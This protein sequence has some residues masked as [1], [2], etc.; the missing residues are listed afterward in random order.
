MKPL[1]TLLFILCFCCTCTFEANAQEWI[2]VTSHYLQN[3][4]FD[5]NQ[6]D[7]WQSTISGGKREARQAA[8]HFQNCSFNFWQTVTDLPDGHYRLSARGFYRTQEQVAAYA[9][10]QQGTEEL[11]AYLYADTSR[12]LL[13]SIFSDTLTASYK[14]YT[15]SPNEADWFPSA[16]HGAS[17]AF[18]KGLYPGVLVEF[19]VKGGRLTVGV[20]CEGYLYNNWCVMDD[21]K[22]EYY[23]TKT[24]ATSLTFPIDTLHLIVGEKRRIEPQMLPLDATYR[25]VSWSS[26][27]QRVATIDS[28]GTIYAMAEGIT[29]VRAKST[30]GS[31]LTARCVVKVE[32][33]EATA[34]SLV[35]NELQVANIDMFLDPSF[36]YGSWVELHNPTDRS[37]SIKGFYVSDDPSD[38][39]RY[40]L[41]GDKEII[42]AHG[43]HVIWFDHYGD[44]AP[45]QIDTKLDCDG[46]AIYISNP[47]G[48]LVCSMTY[49]EALSR[50][51]YARTTD[52]AIEWGITS[53]PTP[54]WSNNTSVFSSVRLD[55]PM[56]DRD[57][58]LFTTPFTAKVEIPEGCTLRYTTDGTSPTL[59]RGEVSTDGLFTVDSTVVYRFRLFRD[60][61][62]PSR[63]VTRSYIYKDKEFAL[64]VLSVATDADHLYDDSIGIFV[65]GVNG[66]T[67][68]GQKTPCNYNMEW[69]RPVSMELILPDGRMVVN[70]EANMEICGGYSRNKA[71][72][73]FKLK[74]NKVYDGENYIPY[75]IFPRKA[76]MKH[77]TWQIRN[78]G[79]DFDCRIK[80]AAVHEIVQ[81]SG[82]DVDGLL[83]QPVVCFVNG[84]YL[85]MMNVRETS[86]KHFIEA[87]YGLDE[88]EIDQFEMT[89]DR[90]AQ[91]YGTDEAFLHWYD[92]ASRS[93]DDSV[94]DELCALVDIDAYVNFMAVQLYMCGADWPQNNVKGFRPLREGGR[95]RLILYDL[96][97]MFNTKNPFTLL[98][99][100]KFVEDSEGN[101]NEVQLVTIFHNLLQNDR[102][103]RRFIDTFALV[104]GSVFDNSRVRAIADSMA[105]AT[106]QALS[107]EGR[108]PWSSAG[109]LKSRL[110][111]SHHRAMMDTLRTYPP[112]QMEGK[113][114]Q[115]VSFSSNLPQARLYMNRIPVPTNRFSGV[116]FPSVT[117]K[118]EAP[119]GYRFV[120]WVPKENPTQVVCPTE[121][122]SLPTSGSHNLVARYE[123]VGNEELPASGFCPVRINEVSAANDIYVSP[124]YFK[125]SDW[126]EL[127]NATS[128]PVDVAG[129]YL[130]D[131]TD[132]PQKWQIEA[133]EGAS[134]LIPPYGHLLVWADKLE[135]VAQ[136]HAPFK[137]DADG[138]DV[139]LTAADGA[140]SDTLS[141]PAHYGY[142]S[143][144]LYPDGGERGYVMTRPTICATNQIGTLSTPLIRDDAEGISSTAVAA[145]PLHATYSDGTLLISG[146]TG[147]AVSV[148]IFD[149]VGIQ[150]CNLSG[151]PSGS[152]TLRLTCPLRPGLY[153]AHIKQ[154]S[155][156][157]ACKFF[158]TKL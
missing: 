8:Y 119:A 155:A 78:G 51:S 49:P 34:E 92:L 18:G 42:P 12:V 43:F 151:R 10:Y 54:G 154:G 36:N 68:N 22:L 152:Q 156:T 29:F 136:L 57:A 133:T 38:P 33:R 117:L 138:G 98:A 48:E 69:D 17:H 115:E 131:R 90:Y 46:G 56:V 52:G 67:G 23:G 135:P 146:L 99:S 129:M 105:T 2:D 110:N 83:C 113:A 60:G 6:S 127:Y 108:S 4:T 62:L 85:A 65:R 81:S 55:A 142:E 19:Q 71:I 140:W 109:S 143:V 145:A 111:A 20:K 144:G 97:R 76:H 31:N 3:A 9:A 45:T 89:G 70:Q 14:T 75:Q 84:E 126:I 39:T 153:I 50:T 132:L 59:S 107:Y 11:H 94:Y 100:K 102:F 93:A 104:G 35:I 28:D 88:D 106:Q 128:G 116:L 158:V 134:T 139:V 25:K 148:S 15:W 87:N 63:I 150:T 77:R 118:A 101:M 40:P 147:D 32:K 114:W 53:T 58:C 30:D 123:L 120:G 26:S 13:P 27:I 61:Y 47:S 141:Y 137:L 124:H 72:K 149:A 157:S 44:E 16:I 73:S 5:K 37:V 24:K 21:F 41:T 130:S 7:G 125:K 86:N 95:F 79:N 80:D 121:E 74:A 64:P 1:N 112:M 96:D 122:Y 91:R 103:R 66:K 82:L